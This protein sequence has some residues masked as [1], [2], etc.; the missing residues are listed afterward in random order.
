MKKSQGHY[1]R[2]ETKTVIAYRI[3]TGEGKISAFEKPVNVNCCKLCGK[4][5]N[6]MYYK[7]LKLHNL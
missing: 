2:N 6:D 4:W 5:C 7:P 3:G 1:Q